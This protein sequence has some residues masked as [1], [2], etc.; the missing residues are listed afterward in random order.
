MRKSSKGALLPS[1]PIFRQPERS[2]ATSRCRS[3]PVKIGRALW[4]LCMGCPTRDCHGTQTPRAPPVAAHNMAAS[5]QT[6][7]ARARATSLAQREP[8]WPK[9]TTTECGIAQRS[10]CAETGSS[11]TNNRATRDDDQKGG[12][13]NDRGAQ[14]WPHCHPKNSTGRGRRAGANNCW[15]RPSSPDP[16]K[17][18]AQ[19]PTPDQ[20]SS[21]KFHPQ[22]PRHQDVD[23]TRRSPRAR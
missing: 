5:S 16:R 14:A 10:G 18:A 3:A 1:G 17:N 15:S 22:N 19:R 4:Q 7:T 2:T 6:C 12:Q 8:P 9:R 23:R 11:V 21:A 20:R 13:D